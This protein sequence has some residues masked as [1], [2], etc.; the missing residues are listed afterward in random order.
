MGI[1]DRVG[2]AIGMRSKI[3]Q[4]IDVLPGYRAAQL[5]VIA[6][7]MLT[8]TYFSEQASAQ[9][10][11]EGMQGGGS[12]EGARKAATP[13]ERKA[14]PLNDIRPDSTPW[15]SD[16]MLDAVAAAIQRYEKLVASGG[17]PAVPAGR[18]MREGDNDP[19]VPTLRKRLRA[20]GD[21]PAK[22]RLALITI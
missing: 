13:L 6:F 9:N 18:M 4:R 14:E 19:R 12:A 16:V 1:G 17:W 22:L 11:Y 21:M 2:R 8:G 15:R 10:W 7:A 20:S 5:A 3:L